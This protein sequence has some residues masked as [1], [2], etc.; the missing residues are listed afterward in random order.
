VPIEELLT[1]KQSVESPSQLL[2]KE[3]QLHEHSSIVHHSPSHEVELQ[4]NH[5]SPSNPKQEEPLRRTSSPSKSR[6]Q[7][8]PKRHSPS[9]SSLIRH[10]DI[11]HSTVPSAHVQNQEQEQKDRLSSA[12]SSTNERKKHQHLPTRSPSNSSHR[13]ELSDANHTSIEDKDT[14][15]IAHQNERI[16]SPN[17]N[18]TTNKSNIS[19]N[20]YQT[21]KQTFISLPTETTFATE[22]R[23]PSSAEK[24]VS[25]Q[26]SQHEP[27]HDERSHRGQQQG[28][29]RTK[30]NPNRSQLRQ[31]NVGIPH[32]GHIIKHIVFTI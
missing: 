20:H 13:S 28:L 24:F 26:H 21:R 29:K 15:S 3:E 9:V 31:N 1:H 5:D 10:K 19:N 4:P 18:D 11:S 14:Q 8:K 7:Q 16:I 25:S 6:H 22:Y 17:H 12:S 27:R 23:R 2:P 30:S 32:K